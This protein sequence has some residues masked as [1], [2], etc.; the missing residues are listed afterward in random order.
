MKKTKTI[1]FSLISLVFLSACSSKYQTNKLPEEEKVTLPKKIKEK[2]YYLNEEVR[3]DFKK[4]VINEFNHGIEKK[5]KDLDK[6]NQSSI[7][8]DIWIQ[9]YEIDKKRY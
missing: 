9:G 8:K 7:P 4:Y 3:N 1:I 5:D 2:K 6:K